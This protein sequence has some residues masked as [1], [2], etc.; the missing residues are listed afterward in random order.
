LFGNFERKKLVGVP[1]DAVFEITERFSWSHFESVEGSLGFVE[2]S[3]NVGKMGVGG[4]GRHGE[5]REKPVPVKRESANGEQKRQEQFRHFLENA[6]FP[7]CGGA[8]VV[9]KNAQNLP[10]C[11][12]AS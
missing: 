7:S 2:L 1:L 9:P 11:S 5:S 4:R 8:G 12:T 3:A 10:G 6:P